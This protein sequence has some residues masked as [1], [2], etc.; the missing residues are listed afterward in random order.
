MCRRVL[1]LALPW[2][3]SAPFLGHAAT[4]TQRQRRQG[5]TSCTWKLGAVLHRPSTWIT[6]VTKSRDAPGST[7]VTGCLICYRLGDCLYKYD[8]T[9]DD[10]RK[11]NRIGDSSDWDHQIELPLAP[12]PNFQ[13]W[14][15]NGGYRPSLLSPH[16]LTFT[17]NDEKH[18]HFQ[19]TLLHALRCKQSSKKRCSACTLVRDNPPI[20]AAKRLRE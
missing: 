7:P 18:Q 15:V 20:S 3:A 9:K 5:V 19:H 6:M 12:S 1:S 17:R 13:W 16:H 10:D 4:G 2:L 11:T 14:N 8:T